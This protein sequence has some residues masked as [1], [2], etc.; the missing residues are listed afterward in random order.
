M[1]RPLLAALSA[2]LLTGAVVSCK[3]VSSSKNQPAGPGAGEGVTLPEGGVFRRA[4]LLKAFGEC[5]QVNARTF[6]PLADELARATKVASETPSTESR[7]AARKAWEGAIDHWQ[8]L[9]VLQYGPAGPTSRPGGKEIRE[10]IYSWP[11]GGRCLVEQIL[12]S[13]GYEPETFSTGL[14][15]T[16]GLLAI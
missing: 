11:L 6:V 14:V 12:A 4:D 7:A 9:E 8:K 1:L 13:K 2:A 5:A 16:R 3:G 10:S 15:S